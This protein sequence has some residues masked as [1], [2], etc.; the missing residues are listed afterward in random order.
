MNVRTI[1]IVEFLAVCVTIPAIII[2]GHLARYMLLVLWLVCLYCVVMDIRLHGK[3]SHR[4]VW[5]PE[6][7]N[8]H[9]MIPMLL[10]WLVCCLGMWVF[11]YFY[12]PGKLFS[13]CR[14]RPEIIPLLMILYPLFSALPQEI[15]FCHYFFRRFEPLFPRTPMMIISSAM[16][17]A[18]AHMLFLNWVAPVFS[19][20]AGLIFARTYART[21]SL[22]LVSLEHA[23][24][25]NAM[26]IIGLGWYFYH[27]AVAP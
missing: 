7:I 12:D 5:R 1:L 21:R 13:L 26:F 9:N 8:R 27:G 16:T 23:L 6:C 15:I 24:Y 11:M 10:R 4:S 18:Y 2:T 22:V 17:F 3:W 25:G 14:T 19:M 20:V